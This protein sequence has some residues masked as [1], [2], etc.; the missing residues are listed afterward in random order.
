MIEIINAKIES[1]FLGFEDHGLFTFYLNLA[2]GGSGGQS[3][4]GYFIVGK[5]YSLIPKILKIVGVE[6]W[7]DLPGKHIR[8]RAEHGKVHEIGNVLEDKWLNFK[9]EMEK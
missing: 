6:K 8:V 1:T 7:E 2:Y 5:F 3:A 9:E 4:G